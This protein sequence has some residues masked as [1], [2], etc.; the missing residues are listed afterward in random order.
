M[1]NA[2]LEHVNVQQGIQYLDIIQS[3]TSISEK[4]II[5]FC[6]LNDKVGSPQKH[7]FIL[8]SGETCVASPTSLRYIFHAFLIL[9]YFTSCTK[10]ESI[11]IV[12]V[13][14]GYGGLCLA[15]SFFSTYFS[16]KIQ[17]Y[18]II[19]L[20]DITQLQQKYLSKFTLEYPVSFHDSALFGSD[21]QSSDNTYLISNYC[22]SEIEKSLQEKY[23]QSLFPNVKHG[24]MAWNFI[25]VYDF[26]KTILKQEDEYPNTGGHLNKYIYF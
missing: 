17:S 19:D 20:I 8:K 22:F 18:S 6:T 7:T 25:P 11:N 16:I 26:G 4:D 21:I 23:I 3:R 13:G 12:E 14:G 5:A 15:L 10:E 2:I 9:N 1:Y 24:F